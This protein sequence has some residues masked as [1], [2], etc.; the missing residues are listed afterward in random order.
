MD[1]HASPELIQFIESSSKATFHEL[2]IEKLAGD[3]SPR[4]YWRL[5]TRQKSYVLLE[6]AP[7]ET[8]KENFSYINVQR[9]LKSHNIH[10]PEIYAFSPKLGVL[11]IEDFGDTFLEKITQKVAPRQY[12][13]YYFLA[14][15]E[16]FKIHFDASTPT[17][18]CL[19]FSLLFNVEKLTWE[20]EFMKTHLIKGYLKISILQKEDKE[21]KEFFRILTS[22]LA[23]QP[24]YFTHRDYHS[25]NLMWHDGKICVLDFQDARLGTCHYDLA[26]LLKDSYVSLPQNLIDELIR[27]YLYEK[28]KRE[29]I[30]VDGEAFKRTFDWMA[31]QRNLKAMGTFAYLHLEKGKSDYLKYLKPTWAYVQENLEKYPEFQKTRTILSGYLGALL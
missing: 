23:N 30:K 11:L 12:A 29:N 3:A 9:H 24:M 15:D 1:F 21:L 28:E 13:K 4:H 14:L 5:K 7:F 19:A 6:T 22:H 8:E 18:D 2:S 31:L 16:L 20:L 10:V 17:K 27:Y 26:S 25:R